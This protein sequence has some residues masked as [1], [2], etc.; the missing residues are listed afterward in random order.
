M[1]NMALFFCGLIVTLIS[2]M[3]VIVFAMTPPKPVSVPRKPEPDIDLGAHVV[4]AKKLDEDQLETTS[5]S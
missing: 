3:G 4:V 2:A 5:A 1:N